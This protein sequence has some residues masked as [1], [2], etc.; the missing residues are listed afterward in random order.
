MATTQGQGRQSS[1]SAE[2]TRDHELPVTTGRPCVYFFGLLVVARPLAPW[3]GTD[4]DI[5]S[6]CLHR[7]LVAHKIAVMI[8]GRSRGAEVPLWR[9]DQTKGKQ[10]VSAIFT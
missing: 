5:A 4:V 9:A 8:S 6:G 2:S 10:G 3:R 7:Q 1:E